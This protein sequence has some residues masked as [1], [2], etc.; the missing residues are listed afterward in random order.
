MG[1]MTDEGPAVARTEGAPDGSDESPIASIGANVDVAA[2]VAEIK[3]EVARK[4]EEGVYP[5]DL[6]T[7]LAASSDRLVSIVDAVRSTSHMHFDPP[8][9]SRRPVVGR[10]ISAAK[11]S[12]RR[13][14]RFQTMWMAA[15]V[16][17]FA[18][19]V[20]QA[21]S[22]LAERVQ[23]VEEQSAMAASQTSHR[24]DRIEQRM[25]REETLAARLASD[26][27]NARDRSV[28]TE[29]GLDYRAFEDRFRGSEEEIGRR[30]EQYV[31]EFQGQR[32]P[33]VDTGC[34]RGEFLQRLRDAGLPAY[35]VDQS[36]GMV[37]R[38]QERGLEVLQ[39]DAVQHLESV[40]PNSLG[41]IFAAQV[42]EHMGP[43]EVISFID[44]AE[45][46][47]VPGGVLVV[48]TLNPQSLS[49]YTGPL[50]V[51]LGH[52]RPLHPSTLRFLA[53]RAGFQSIDVRFFSPIPD[54]QRLLPL[55][56]Q[57]GQAE[58][59]E[60]ISENFRRIDAMLFGPLDFALVAKR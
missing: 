22:I 51:D 20:A 15:Q 42:L 9:S 44:L 52:A 39:G 37:A 31:A 43:D 28:G 55:P 18:G 19:N 33:I 32:S 14:L 26:R 24:V 56:A 23:E 2:L 6:M 49:T 27:S 11:Y 8:T 48:E 3:A 36:P 50:Y 1:R 13:T 35:G 53:E 47:L 54:D 41:G 10:V 60:A 40:G 16:N 30:Q 59:A 29:L 46:A 38:C 57:N 4:A 34:G 45:R 58:L 17:T 21:T 7:E 5:P 12:I 25:R